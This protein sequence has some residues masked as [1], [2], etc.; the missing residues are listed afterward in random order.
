MNNFSLVLLF[1]ISLQLH[2]G[3][4]VTVE[5]NGFPG[6][7]CK[8]GGDVMGRC[9]EVESCLQDGGVV[10]RDGKVKLCLKRDSKIY[11]CCRK[12]RRIADELCRSWR[13][14]WRRDNGECV[15]E[16]PLIFGGGNAKLGE[17]PPIALLS[18]KTGNNV[19]YFCGGTLISPHFVLTAAHCLQSYGLAV[20]IE[21][22]LGEHDITTTEMAQQDRLSGSFPLSLLHAN[23]LNLD[24]TRTA[25]TKQVIKVEKIIHPGYAGTEVKYHDIALLKLR[26]PAVLTR[27]VLPACLHSNPTEL[28]G[29]KEL[30]VAGWG[31]T[32]QGFGE[33]ENI[34]QKVLVPVE[35]HLKCQAKWS[36]ATSP[37]R[38]ILSDQIC[39]GGNGR[40]SCR[41]D[42]GGP[43]I[44]R[45][46]V[47]GKQVC[48]Q[49]LVG[50]VSFGGD[51]GFGG[52]Y[53]RVSSY[54][55]WIM[56]YIAPHGSPL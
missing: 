46:T 18:T 41:G 39:A 15:Q 32:Y 9:E 42:S 48:E 52:I 24:T 37:P 14:F 26:T 28:F 27:R 55:D 10:R 20:Q 17:L 13:Q 4:A 40:D 2:G 51:C 8:M 49:T 5:G 38:G 25:P 53:T 11:V 30:T 35:N 56:G 3:G 43:L 6:D 45:A 33:T 16:T 12:P 50:V 44:D 21:V 7:P 34:L 23:E 29:D 1:V 54:L 47:D 19:V 36:K 22:T 31:Y